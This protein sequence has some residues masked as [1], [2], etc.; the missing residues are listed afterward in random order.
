MM[1]W[2]TVFLL[3]E[4]APFP[5][6]RCVHQRGMVRTFQIEMDCIAFPGLSFLW[7]GEPCWFYALLFYEHRSGHFSP[8][9]KPLGM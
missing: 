3:V 8:W 5:I 6:S 7:N 4:R 2:I 9:N 1:S